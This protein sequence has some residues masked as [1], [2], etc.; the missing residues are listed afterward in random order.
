MLDKC[1]ECF[2]KL[3]KIQNFVLDTKILNNS[4]KRNNSENFVKF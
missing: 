2:V 1:L 3:K 4:Q